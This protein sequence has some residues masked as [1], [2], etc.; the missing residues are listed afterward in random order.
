M[1]K[2]AC[3]QEFS[4]LAVRALS[5]RQGVLLGSHGMIAVGPDLTRT[6]WLAGELETL[7]KRP[8]LASLAGAPAILSDDETPASRALFASYGP[9]AEKV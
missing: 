9:G 7:T 8:Y 6:P 2:P 4:D 5:P 1:K 3:A